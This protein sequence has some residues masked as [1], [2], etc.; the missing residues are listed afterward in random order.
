MTARIWLII[1]LKAVGVKHRSRGIEQGVNKRG[2]VQKGSPFT[3]IDHEI[4][5]FGIHSRHITKHRAGTTRGT[6]IGRRH[7]AAAAIMEAR[8]GN[9][10]AVRIDQIDGEGR[11]A[12]CTALTD[13]MGFN[14]PD[15]KCKCGRRAWPNFQDR[16]DGKEADRNQKSNTE[17]IHLGTVRLVQ[18]Q[19]ARKSNR[20]ISRKTYYLPCN[21]CT[22]TIFRF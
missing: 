19:E 13:L 4:R 7:P 14:G 10:T 18:N 11:I 12:V 8:L 22:R 9:R 3:A 2:V 16:R 5:P 21:C 15:G 6:T 17:P 1:P 20:N